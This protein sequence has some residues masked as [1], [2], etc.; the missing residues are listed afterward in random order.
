MSWKSYKLGELLERKR[1]K[2]DIKPDQDYKL[3]TIRLWHQ[4]VV[5]RE[6]KS[7]QDIKSNMYHVNEG[8]FVLSGIDARNGAFGIVPKELEGAVVTNDFW[9]LVP[10]KSLLR[11][12]FFLFLTSTKFFDFICN[13]CS[14]GT[15]Q[16][17][18]L[19]K[20][21]FYDFEIALPP[22]E[23]QEDLVKSLAKSKKSN[24]DLSTELTHQLDLVK[25]LRQAFLRE[26]MQGKLVP[27]DEN[28]E[29]ALVLLE[30]IKAEKERLV[31]DK[32]IKKQKPLPPITEDEIPFDI[33]ENWVWCHFG[34]LCELINGDRSKN[35]PN[36]HEY[37]TNGIPW[38]NTGHIETD[39]TLSVSEMYFITKS[40]FD[41]LRS[42]KIKRGDLVY[43]LRGATFGKTAFVKPYEIGAIASS[44]MIIRLLSD[45]SN[46]YVFYF[47]KSDYAMQQLYRF[48][49]GSAQP[50]LAAGDVNLYYFPLPPLSEQQRIVTKLDELMQYCDE[51]E[52]SIKESQQQ[53]ELLLQ[54]VLR[55]ALEPSYA[56]ASESRPA[57]DKSTAGRLKEREVKNV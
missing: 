33:P 16:R 41:S 2:A 1:E 36:R 51:L 5:L 46:E 9:C 42:G 49:N 11:K 24:E 22:I 6:E 39:G 43:C 34:E 17:I 31:K 13:Q 7:G 50:N 44:L 25:Q 56:K 47:L 45:I 55:E 8:D 10:K 4:G 52:A 20:D 19:Q 53:N 28:G 35:Y 3:V 38:I 27:Q 57:S 30:K 29:P 54:Q 37:V 15:T 14:D 40:K 26:A 12:D 48:N 32:K 18:R 21:K 23:E